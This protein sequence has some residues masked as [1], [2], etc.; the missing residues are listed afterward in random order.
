MIKSKFISLI[1][2]VGMAFASITASAQS[3]D[4]FAVATGNGA[5]GSTYSAMFK[6]FIG[7]CSAE[8]GHSFVEVETNGSI[9]NINL[10]SGNKVNGAFV[11]SDLL[12]FYNMTDPESVK[13]IKTVFALHP[14]ELH[15]IARSD[16]VK[17]G[18]F[19]GFGG[20][21]VSYNSIEDL[22][23]RKV[24]AVGGSVLSG[25]VIA[26]K[27][28]IDFDIVEYKDN[29]TLFNALLTGE[30][31][32]IL[33]VGGAPHKAVMTLD[34]RYK[35]LPVSG[36]LAEKIATGSVYKTAKVSYS[37]LNQAG[38][39][40]IAVEAL[41]VSRTYRSKR[42]LDKLSAARSCLEYNLAD[43]QDRRGTHPKWQQVEEDN[44][45]LWSYYELD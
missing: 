40:T 1:A 23:G 32:S 35:I 13:N 17:E 15:F 43:I 21:E 30:V 34:T 37:N 12:A 45:G 42:V 5:Q 7:Q 24:G 6:E 41:F 44:K 19:M 11:Q 33:V 27:S 25:R 39:D 29:G 2:G 4:S 28:D 18:G 36:K 3:N 14:E 22:Q 31:D 16:T 38:V 8:L 10:L 20:N 9:E 26:S